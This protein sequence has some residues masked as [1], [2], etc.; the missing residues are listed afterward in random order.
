MSRVLL[1]KGI[2]K[3]CFVRRKPLEQ[4]FV[5]EVH[6]RKR[7]LDES[8]PFDIYEREVLARQKWFPYFVGK[9]SPL[10]S[11]GE[12][13]TCC[14]LESINMHA[15]SPFRYNEGGEYSGSAYVFT[16]EP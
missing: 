7:L 11:R 14:T 12:P 13:R 5:F 2:E 9:L 16:P 6:L 15:R 1:S 8:F 10:Y 3:R 4:R